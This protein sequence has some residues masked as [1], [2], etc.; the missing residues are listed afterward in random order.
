VGP[1]AAHPHGRDR[2]G[3]R[4]RLHP[5]RRPVGR[6]PRLHCRPG[7]GHP[8]HRPPPGSHPGR[9]RVRISGLAE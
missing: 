6:A 8:A 1:G 9:P 3:D 4:H 7:R 2:A 5:A